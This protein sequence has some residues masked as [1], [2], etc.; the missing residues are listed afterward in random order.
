M[1]QLFCARHT[2]LNVACFVE[3]LLHCATCMVH[4]MFRCYFIVGQTGV[5]IWL[6]WCTRDE[7]EDGSHTVLTNV[8]TIYYSLIFSAIAHSLFRHRDECVYVCWW[9]PC[10]STH[11]LVSKIFITPDHSHRVPFD[12]CIGSLI[13]TRC[14]RKI[15]V[16]ARRT[17]SSWCKCFQR[18]G[19]Q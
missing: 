10:P 6:W 19:E 12:G 9:P 2:C 5:I 18:M 1:L 7:E 15:Y 17:S 13:G 14:Y 11:A 3:I 8:L 16:R 4:Y